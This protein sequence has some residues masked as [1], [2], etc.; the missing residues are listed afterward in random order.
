MLRLAVFAS[1]TGSNLQTLI[2]HF[3][4]RESPLVRVSLVVSDRRDAP[5][6]DRA[7]AA[8]IPARVIP[9]RGRDEGDLAAEMLSALAHSGIDL[10]ALAGYLRL[11]P[12]E[13]IASFRDRI[14]NIHPALLPAFGGRGMYGLH[15]HRAVI[16]A[17]CTVS[18]ATVHFVDER[19]DEGR[20]LVQWPVPVRPDDTPESL[21]ARVLEVEHVLYPLALEWLA[22]RVEHGGHAGAAQ[23]GTAG[24]GGP[25]HFALAADAR[26]VE[27]G[28]RRTLFGTEA[29]P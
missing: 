14:V 7:S 23:P 10:I 1:G 25:L 26:G 9:A 17:G 19:Y 2:D 6:L 3:N 8:A 18:G 21:A 28:V 11:L 24:I 4:A 13:V 16:A 22:A 12:A 29:M 27:M 15:V 20:V 5:A